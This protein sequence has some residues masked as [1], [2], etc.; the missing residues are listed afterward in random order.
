MYKVLNNKVL[1]F[2]IGILLL[3]NITMLVFFLRTKEPVKKEHRGERRKSPVAVFLEKDLQ[4]N[5]QQI[6]EFEK[7]RSEHRQNMKSL[8]E[9]L[10]LAKVRFYGHLQN[11]NVHDSLLQKDASIIG[12][13]Q[14]AVD[15]RAF[16]NFR[17]LRTLCSSAQQPRYDS[18]ISDVI[19]QMWFPARKGNHT[20]KNNLPDKR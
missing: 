18:L 15:L 20:D 16:Q 12:D 11:I 2:I 19:G 6:A 1:L 13:I 17:E 7:L 10:R 4:F 3:A 8:A 9:N 14:K 5:S